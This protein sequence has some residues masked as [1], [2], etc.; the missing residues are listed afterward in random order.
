M[1]FTVNT[2]KKEAEKFLSDK[3]FSEHNI[4]RIIL[5]DTKFKEYIERRGDDI[6]KYYQ[7][8]LEILQAESGSLVVSRCIRPGTRVGNLYSMILDNSTETVEKTLYPRIT[9]IISDIFLPPKEFKELLNNSE[10]DTNNFYISRVIREHKSL[11]GWLAC[12]DSGK[13]T[14]LNNIGE[15]NYGRSHSMLDLIYY[16]NKTYNY[17]ITMKDKIEEI[18]L[19]MIKNGE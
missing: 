3:G 14:G 19:N 13:V 16:L 17:N 11:M 2:N 18:L 4:L 5:K 10:E 1:K 12:D 7:I 15:N 8:I 6:T 9:G